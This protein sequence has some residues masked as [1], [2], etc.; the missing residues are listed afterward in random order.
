MALS[1]ITVKG[2]TPDLTVLGGYQ[3]FRFDTDALSKLQSFNLYSPTDIFTDGQNCFELRNYRFCGYRFKQTT[4]FDELD[5]QGTFKFQYFL[6]D[7]DGVD[8][9]GY[10][11]VYLS[12]DA[13]VQFDS[14]YGDLDM[15]GYR[16][17]NLG[18][19][20]SANDA[21]T[22]AYV[23]S[24][25][26]GGT[27]AV[28]LTGD[29]T[30]SGVVG[31][32]FA[33]TLT[34]R[35]DQI[36]APT[37]S[38]SLNSQKITNLATPTLTTDAANK[39]YVDGKTWTAS[40]I[41]D[42]TSAVTAF[43]LD[44]FATP[45]ANVSIG[46][47]KI[48]NLGTP[49]ASADAATKAY[50]DSAI[51]AGTVSLTGDVTGSGV[52][53]TPFATTF[54]LR[55]DQI[56]APTASVSLNSQKITNLATP[57]LTTDAATKAYVDSAAA[58][59]S[60]PTDYY[61]SNAF[62]QNF[63]YTA[64]SGYLRIKNEFVPGAGF[65]SYENIDLINN[66]SYGFRFSHK[67][68]VTD[69]TY[70][71]LNIQSRDASGQGVGTTLLT[72]TA[73]GLTS[74]VPLTM[75]A[76]IDMST[77]NKIVN[78]ASP[79]DPNDAANMA[80]VDAMNTF[81]GGAFAFHSGS[82]ITNSIN[83][84]SSYT[85]I[86]GFS[87]SNN[88][89]FT[90]AANYGYRIAQV[91]GVGDTYGTFNLYTTYG[92]VI[93]S[94]LMAITPTGKIGIGV[95]APHGRIH[96]DNTF[97]N[98]KI[99]LYETANN[100]FQFMGFGVTNGVLEYHLNAT[101]SEHLFYAA[102]S[103]SSRNELFRIK[104]DGSVSV[105][106]T[107]KLGI[108][109][110]SPNAQLQFDNTL[111]NRKIVLYEGA[112]NNFQ[113]RGFGSE[114]NALTYV[115]ETNTTDHIFFAG[116][117]SAGRT[118][119]CRI[120]GNGSL[121]FPTSGGKIGLGVSTPNAQLHF[122]T[123]LANRKIVLYEGANNN[124]QFRGF[125]TNS[126]DL[127]YNT[128][129]TSI[130]HVF[131]AGTSSTTLNELMRIKGNGEIVTTGVMYNKKPVGSCYMQA[132]VTSTALTANTWTKIAGATTALG[133]NNLFTMPANNRL[134]SGAAQTGTYLVSVSGNVTTST[135]GA[136]RFGVAIYKNGVHVTPSATYLQLNTSDERLFSLSALV[137]LASGDYVEAWH[138]CNAA[139]TVTVKDMIVN[140]IAANA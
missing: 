41:T 1:N 84:F 94:T 46:G 130:D 70:G 51:T 127:M 39:S 6:D 125:G 48:T 138:V 110:S 106:D 49:T 13:P 134:T 102:A 129:S 108:G 40:Q 63:I 90:N 76:D 97:E 61:P 126:T 77:T 21:A 16:I 8:I 91:T 67:T 80:Y 119:L 17:I 69:S 132:N 89:T 64:A 33:T 71:V 5:R 35:L 60:L 75:D 37:A 2:I 74:L 45:S 38:V 30:G 98:R 82:S 50:V 117:T 140:V 15:G 100:L 92:G 24:V 131:S 107:G 103:S 20:S 3:R 87:G 139:K 121:I 81:T 36:I 10:N 122:D 120:K 54:T 44:Q 53:G 72:L 11:G 47:F 52:V 86:V 9:W 79:S 128:E 109:V 12:F 137:S 133:S 27:G 28:S 118:T 32:P 88:V 25:T 31:T 111:A 65:P 56:T 73:T 105:P 83:L 42:F 116:A 96:I 101:A 66:N 55:L 78:L 99:I 4:H 114:T 22:K 85:P 135:A 113:F 7:G 112:N 62:S 115:V 57:T 93:D 58:S 59:A 14:I 68:L 23:D 43:R 29:V 18:A 19:P 104:G 136:D 26:G 124:F 123:T 34:L 95:A